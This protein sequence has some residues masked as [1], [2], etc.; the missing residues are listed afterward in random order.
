MASSYWPLSGLRL[1]TPLVELR[2]PGESDLEALAELAA[3][4]VHAPGQQ[5]FLTPWATAPPAERA[6]SVLQ[7]QWRQRGAWTPE[8]W[9]LELAVVRDGVLVGIQS[10]FGTSFAARR[11]V[12]TGSWLGLAHHG[13]GTGTQMRAAV[14]QLAFAGLGAE[15]AV[16]GAF[17]DNAASLGVSRKLGY[18]DDGIEIDSVE[19]QAILSRRLRLDRATWKRNQSVP[20]EI[21]G[22]E[23]CLD[24]FGLP[25]STPADRA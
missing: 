20:V 16:S 13:R 15:Y 4:G 9:T 21:T 10:V 23:P 11:E 3:A 24:L 7:Y 1:R 2:W 5:P 25:A 8:A 14:L 6:R 12:A 18:A 19:G 17:A 22:L